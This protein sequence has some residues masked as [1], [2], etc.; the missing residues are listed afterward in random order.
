M[1]RLLNRFSGRSDEL[2]AY[3]DV[4][5]KLNITQTV[6]RGLQE[7]PMQAIVG[8]VGRAED[9]TREFL[10][11]RD[12][13]AERWANV[14]AAVLDMKGWSP[15]EVYQVGD[16][17]FV[18]DGNHRV[19]VARE[20]GNNTIAAYVTEIET[21]LPLSAGDDPTAVICRANYV[22]FLEKTRL[23]Q[24]RPAADLQL[25]FCAQYTTLLSQILH[26][27]KRLAAQGRGVSFQEASADWYD[28]VYLPVVEMIRKQGILHEFQERTEGD[29]Y[30]LLS[31]RQEELEEALGWEVRPQSAL[32]DW[33]ASLSGSRSPLI[34]RLGSRL[35][36]AVAPDLQDGPPPGEWRRQR[37]ATTRDESLF[38]DILV[39]IQ[40][41][42]ADWQLLDNTLLVAQ[43]EE[44][45]VLCIH[46]VDEEYELQN[47]R[48][49]E[50]HEEFLR[51]CLAAGVEGQFAAEVGAEAKL[52]I[53]RAPWVDLVTTN[54]TFA[55]DFTPGGR[56]SSSVDRL[57]RRCPRPILVMAGEEASALD[58]ALLAYD[59]SP[60]SDEA[61]FVATYLAARWQI[62]LTV[63]TVVTRHTP[64]ATLDRARRYLI[65]SQLINVRYILAEEP[66]TEAVIDTAVA[67]DSNLLIMG[68][69]GY[70]PV[71]HL[72][73]GSTVDGVM[74]HFRVPTL[75]CR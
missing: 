67:E 53:H 11:K 48:T 9:F 74:E 56:L 31:E 36:G 7:I 20:L 61:L 27:Q 47:A 10:P 46:A 66:I 32:A 23:D 59:G 18:K 8:S 6:E 37:G 2:L 39:S 44:A 73:L 60:K 28:A 40:G 41:S 4:S 75:I 65:G 24:T 43:R 13:D 35:R 45:A 42:E 12:S 26:H 25:T 19:S 29:I 38:G 3:S 57:I 5:D 15:I 55:S 21:R 51:R 16:V 14:K 17:Y 64:A 49:R 52:L 54:L 70:R 58:R 34:A 30:I 71:Q 72:V 68:G 63:L 69:F 22:D 50:I 62:D 1:R 33:A